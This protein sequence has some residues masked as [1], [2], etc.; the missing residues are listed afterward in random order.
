MDSSSNIDNENNWSPPHDSLVNFQK[1][2]FEGNGDNDN[3][4]D[5]EISSEDDGSQVIILVLTL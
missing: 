1:D 4:S 3:D 5:N 2:E